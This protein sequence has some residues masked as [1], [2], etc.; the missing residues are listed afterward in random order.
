MVLSQ[1]L[2]TVQIMAVQFQLFN[3]AALNIMSFTVIF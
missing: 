3:I 1:Y 2:L